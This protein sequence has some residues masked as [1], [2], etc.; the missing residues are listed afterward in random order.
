M[1]DI[2]G[3]DSGENKL[4]WDACQ[5]SYQ[6]ELYAKPLIKMARRFIGKRILDA[7][8]GAGDLVRH[9][10]RRHPEAKIVGIDIAPKSEDV[11]AGDISDLPFSDGYFDTIFCV[12]V[13]EHLSA[14]ATGR[15]LGEFRRLLAPGGHVII[16]TPFAED[17]KQNIVK[18]PCCG[19]V[20]H[21]WG[22]QQSFDIEDFQ[23]L[24]LRHHWKV[25]HII[26]V[27]MTRLARFSGV[28]SSLFLSDM[29][30]K[31]PFKG[32]GKLKLIFI[33]EAPR[34]VTG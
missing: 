23:R 22:H 3:F 8:A 15:T 31:W 5:A 24:A 1:V 13:I 6:G 19:T 7:G 25:K 12:E 9:L 17:L 30:M 33:A 28:A 27:K 16:T 18:C 26:P 14:E 4:F 29:Y 2:K 10:G 34:G 20:F 11:R 32:K 21:R